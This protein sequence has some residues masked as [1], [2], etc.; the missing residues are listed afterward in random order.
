M[1]KLETETRNQ[2]NNYYNSK[3]KIMEDELENLKEQYRKNKIKEFNNNEKVLKVK[4]LFKEIEK[5]Y[6]LLYL[7]LECKVYE[8][9]YKSLW[10]YSEDKEIS[11]LYKQI[12]NLKNERT[13]LILNLETFNKNTKEYKEVMEKFIN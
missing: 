13:L 9:S 1:A 2:I 12:T 3:I 11:K 10:K 5:E 6:K 7:N 4:E 8:S